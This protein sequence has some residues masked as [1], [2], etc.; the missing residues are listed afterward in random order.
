M[1]RETSFKS[2]YG[3]YEALRSPDTHRPLAVAVKPGPAYLMHNAAP[4]KLKMW[5]MHSVSGSVCCEVGAG[6]AR[7]TE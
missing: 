4:V 1:N 7:L 5:E 3:Y 2:L 6:L